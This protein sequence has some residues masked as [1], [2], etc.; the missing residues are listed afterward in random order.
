MLFGQGAFFL[1]DILAFLGLG[2]EAL[3][4]RIQRC[5]SRLRR[6]G[7]VYFQA[8]GIESCRYAETLV[9]IVKDLAGVAA[10]AFAFL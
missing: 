10:L 4:H 6:N 3:L 7:G 8:F 9:G 1:H 2:G 5:L